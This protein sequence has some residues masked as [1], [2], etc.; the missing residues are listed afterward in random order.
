MGQLLNCSANEEDPQTSKPTGKQTK[1]EAP[2]NR[3]A[4][5]GLT[6]KDSRFA[7]DHPVNDPQFAELFSTELRQMYKYLERVAYDSDY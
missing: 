4:A 3:T 2:K 5:K 7:A 6:K 1:E